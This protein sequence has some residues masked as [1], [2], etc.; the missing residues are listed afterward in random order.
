MNME[1]CPGTEEVKCFNFFV[2]PNHC[3]TS[4]SV[5]G[6]IFTLRFTYD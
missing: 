3:Q 4:P 2:T 1:T 6:H 5:L